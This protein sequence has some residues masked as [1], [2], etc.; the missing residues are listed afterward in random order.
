VTYTT[1][2]LPVE[3][4]LQGGV[5]SHLRERHVFR[6]RKCQA[7]EVS[8]TESLAIATFPA[9]SATLRCSVAVRSAVNR[10]WLWSTDTPV[11]SA[12]DVLRVVA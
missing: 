6:R 10:L 11:L 1:T 3:R 12:N 8:C 9:I 5:Y 4:Q 7:S 2:H